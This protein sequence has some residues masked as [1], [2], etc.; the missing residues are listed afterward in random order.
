M[1]GLHGVHVV[2]LRPVDLDYRQDQE[3]VMKVWLEVRGCVE[4]MQKKQKTVLCGI[5]KVCIETYI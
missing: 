3:S 4:E 2:Q 1:Y 5:V